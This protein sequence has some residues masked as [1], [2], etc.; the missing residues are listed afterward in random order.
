MGLLSIIADA[1]GL[2]GPL[3]VRTATPLAIDAS[4][5]AQVGPGQALHLSTHPAARGRTVRAVT[6]PAE[7][8][9]TLDGIEVVVGDDDLRLL[10]GLRIAW[11]GGRF[12]VKLDLEV[13]AS[14]TPNPHSRMFATD[15]VLCTG[16]P[17]YASPSHHEAP[18][19]AVAILSIEGVQTVLLR[20]NTLT[21]TRHP[22]ASW[23]RLDKAVAAALQEHF[24]GCGQPDCAT[25]SGS[26]DDDLTAA[27][28]KVLADRVLPGVHRDG[29]NIEIIDISDG[30][31]RVHMEG[32]CQQCPASTITL[33]R[34][35]L[36]VL[37]EEFPGRVTAVEQV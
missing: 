33:N 12:N 22:D 31:V 3:T 27:L 14:E 35:V 21:V 15:R 28:R 36:S 4:A 13:R 11:T 6:G 7:G 24:L 19:L 10:Q 26:R 32:A 9:R 25:A 34:V 18:P 5:A 23:S 1:L 20:H 2:R 8:A 29:G 17:V 16:A 37:Q 30:V